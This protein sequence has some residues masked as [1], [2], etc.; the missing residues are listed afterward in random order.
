M[1]FTMTLQQVDLLKGESDVVGRILER[2]TKAMNDLN[3]ALVTPRLFIITKPG[4]IFPSFL[5]KRYADRQER[6]QQPH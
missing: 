6:G 5:E 2:V 4:I 1:I 3:F